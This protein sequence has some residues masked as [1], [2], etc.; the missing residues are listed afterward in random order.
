MRYVAPEL[1][2][3]GWHLRRV[4]AQSGIVLILSPLEQGRLS[5]DSTPGNNNR[6]ILLPSDGLPAQ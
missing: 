5:G 6:E 1:R 2:A 3:H 4:K